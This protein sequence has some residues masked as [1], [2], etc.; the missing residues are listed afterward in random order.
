LRKEYGTRPIDQ[1]TFHAD[2]AQWFGSAH[3]Y[4]RPIDGLLVQKK[5]EKRRKEKRKPHNGSENEYL[6]NLYWYH[7]KSISWS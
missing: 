3:A 4:S 5:K 2:P 6:Y 1:T 7:A